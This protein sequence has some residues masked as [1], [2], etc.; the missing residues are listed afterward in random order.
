YALALAFDLVPEESRPVAVRRLVE[1]VRRFKH[2]T[3][4]F[5]GTPY[6][7][8]VLSASGHLADA[9][10]L[11]LR[12]QYPS[13]LYPIKQ[14]ATTIW[15]RWDGEK[16][17][18]S[19]QDPEMNSFNHYAYGAV[20]AWLY[21][22]VAGIEIDPE[23]PGYKHVLIQPQPGGGLTHV[24]ASLNTLYG[25]VASAWQLGDRQFTLDVTIP[26]NAS[27]TASLP[28]AILERV[29]ES[30]T[31]LGKAAGISSIRQGGD[32]VIVEIGS[33]HYRFVYGR[34]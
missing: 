4:G 14:G 8:P 13:W 29:T 24:R 9:Y 6:L 33:G 1:D 12:D 17:D 34:R 19:F 3:T 11:L 27:A 30:G 20:G 2:L 5:L 15:E 21:N 16:P 25:T 26:P 31:P 22:T 23:R 10:A 28:G 18:S 32:T 7:N